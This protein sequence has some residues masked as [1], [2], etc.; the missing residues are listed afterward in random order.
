MTNVGAALT[1]HT[2]RMDEVMAHIA[3]HRL[4]TIYPVVWNRGYTLHPSMIAF[5]AAG[6]SRNTFT[7]LPLLPFLDAL[8]GLIHQAHR[9]HLRLIP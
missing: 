7:S 3:E 1:Y 4:N 2:T 5:Q 6:W 9:Q 8:I